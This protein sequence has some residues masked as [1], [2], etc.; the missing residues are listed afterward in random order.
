MERSDAVP[1]GR[2]NEEPSEVGEESSPA[3]NDQ[4]P[5]EAPA[6]L[7]VA[8]VAAHFGVA[9]SAVYRWI[10]QGELSA[11]GT[12]QRITVADVEALE[13]RRRIQPGELRHLRT[14]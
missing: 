12:P 5:E 9:I 3:V 2:C 10:R 11:I 7:T 6:D 8:E 4:A 14:T 13:G 1:P